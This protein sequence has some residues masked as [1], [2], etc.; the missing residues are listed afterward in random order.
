MAHGSG[1]IV[2]AVAVGVAAVL[3]V[4]GSVTVA[5]G[6]GGQ[7][8]DVAVARAPAA[9]AKKLAG[10]ALASVRPKVVWGGSKGTALS[11]RK[12][13]KAKLGK[14]AG[15]PASARSLLVQVTVTGAAKDGS[16]S[17][18][19]AGK[20]A[21]RTVAFSKGSSSATM[22]VATSAGRKVS[23]KSTAK[24]RVQIAVVGFA[25]ASKKGGPAPGGSRAVAATPVLDSAA[26]LGGAL[27]GKGRWGE[28]SVV[29]KGGVPTEGVRAVWLSVQA[30]GR[31]AGLLSFR[32]SAGGTMTG[33]AE[34][35]AK[36]WSTSLVLA[37][38]D[39][40]GQVS[41]KLA[42]GSLAGL[43]MAVVGWVAETALSSSAA[44]ANGGVVPVASKRAAVKP[45][46]SGSGSARMF[47]AKVTGGAVPAAVSEVLVRVTLSSTKGWSLGAGAS[48]ASARRGSVGGPAGKKASV[49]LPARVG[50]GGK[51]V[52]AVGGGARVVS[53]KVV[54]YLAGGVKASKGARAPKVTF[55][56]INGGKPVDLAATPLVSLS[57][58][59]SDAGSGVR[60][61]RVAAGST[62]LGSARVDTTVR[63]ARWRMEVALPEGSVKVTATAVNQAGAKKAA[64]QAAVVRYPKPEETVVSERAVTLDDATLARITNLSAASI[65]FAGTAVPADPGAVIAAGISPATPEGLLRR[66]TAVS[67]TAATVVLATE[68]AT[69]TDAFYQLA[70]DEEDVELEQDS[71][72]GEMTPAVEG[73][74][75]VSKSL[76]YELS[77]G[78]ENTKSGAKVA[79]T[80]KGELAVKAT[81]SVKL[82][83]TVESWTPKI[84]GKVD[85]FEIALAPELT[86]KASVALKAEKKWE[87]RQSLGKLSLHTIVIMAGVV[88]IVISNTLEPYVK[89]STTVFGE[90]S[91]SL[92]LTAKVKV[93][94]RYEDDKWSPF[95]DPSL[96]FD[97][98]FELAVGLVLGESFGIDYSTKLYGVGG[99]YTGIEQKLTHEGKVVWVNA[100]EFKIEIKNTASTWAKV[101]AKLEVFS[102]ELAKY[103]RSWE[104][105]KFTLPTWTLG[106]WPSSSQPTPTPTLTLSPTSVSIGSASGSTATVS[107]AT[108]Q[109]AWRITACPSWAT[110]T[111]GTNL[112]TVKTTSAAGSANRSAALTVAAGA[113]S[114]S[115][116]IT[117]SVTVTQPAPTLTL[118]STAVALASASG[119]TG[120]VSVS[121]NQPSWWFSGCPIWAMCTKGT[122]SI[123]VKAAS[124][125]PSSPRSAT[126]TVSAGASSSLALITK[127]V[128]FTQAATPSLTLSPTSVSIGSASGST[129]TVSVS[130]NQ[131]TWRVTACPSWA[132]CTKGTSSITVKTTSAAGSSSRSGTMTVAAGAT[133]TS[134][135]ISKS[136]T[137]TQAATATISLS[138]TTWVIDARAQTSPQITVTTNQSRWTASSNQSWLTLSATSG[139]SGGRITLSAKQNNCALITSSRTGV[140]TFTAGTAQAKLTV[141][142]Y[143]MLP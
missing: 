53:V 116:T 125:G 77:S 115:S 52:L 119:S 29:G 32:S 94:L 59:V 66:V 134:T 141:T 126:L 103:E 33:V 83:I 24:A 96:K 122:T 104:V 39:S 4:F 17:I 28:V 101:G 20:K 140:V 36:R 110:C 45:L 84:K 15:V 120:S 25:A 112:I 75:S 34:V 16:L 57:G 137:I 50:S 69:L 91:A 63:P 76:K 9:K 128:T 64:T 41:W 132:T 19:P 131:A 78:V 108:N 47:A 71:D 62:T 1:R 13:V 139:S 48:T 72:T 43:R 133:S 7:A 79:V 102:K 68:Q 118:S 113:T 70:L 87:K 27:P 44:T 30:K 37:P 26:K 21:G 10:G 143:C 90:A 23:V 114:T 67:K 42:S 105:K 31:S 3:G 109:A 142:Q 121:T 51:V 35:L 99:P 80:F 135:A 117:R 88:P 49:L 97:P 38:V 92:A 65:T 6:A 14:A 85:F 58:T 11:A 86:A 136:A 46:G 129:A 61:V 107:V 55:A 56:P 18:V 60:S 100:S 81:L 73:S 89:V 124:A 74:V 95:A 2:R 123:T 22:L 93:G 8:G 40:R 5:A 138:Q 82:N 54:G 98:K 111:K 12:T 127:T 106:P 130:T